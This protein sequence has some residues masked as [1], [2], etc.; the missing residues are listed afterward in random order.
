MS[1]KAVKPESPSDSSATGDKRKSVGYWRETWRRYRKK[2]LASA[3][4]IFVGFLMMVAAFSPA[5]VGTKPVVLYFEGRYYFPAMAYFNRDWENPAV[6]APFRK[7][8]RPDKIEKK[9]PEAWA[10]WPL[11]FQDPERIVRSNEWEGQ[12]GNPTSNRGQPYLYYVFLQGWDGVFG[13]EHVEDNFGD[14]VP[15]NLL[16]TTQNGLDVFAQLVHGTRTALFVGFVSMGIASCIGITLG[17]IAGYGAGGGTQLGGWIDIAIS[18]LIELVMCIPTIVIVLTALSVIEK[19]TIWH[20]MA[21]LGATS[22]TGIARLMRAEFLK[23]SKAEYVTA[24]RSLGVS[25]V[26]IMFRHI[27][28]NALAP[29]LTPIVFGIASAVLIESALS[30]LGFGAPPPTPSWGNLL[31]AGQANRNMWWLIVC[32][33]MA[34]FA[35]VLTYNLIGEGVQEATDPRLKQTS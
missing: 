17:A 15:H 8:Y 22:W 4:L 23:L 16:G 13:T 29:V 27:L 18:R 1:N 35:T 2:K 19:P 24:A 30:F 10:I 34:I 5:I 20:I 9:D 26:R 28:P 14:T 25:N 3:A 6:S 21:L 32:P 12:P 33:G 31:R 11:V 7:R